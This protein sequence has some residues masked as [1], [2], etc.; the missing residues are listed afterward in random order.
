MSEETAS[1]SWYAR[2]DLRRAAWFA[3]GVLLLLG[4]AAVIAPSF[5]DWN[6]YR[7]EI[8][9]MAERAT[10]RAVTIGGD[11]SFTLLPSPAL[12]VADLRVANLAGFEGASFARLDHL[13]V[14]V[15]ALPLLAGDLNLR[16]LVLNAPVI[17]LE[18]LSD[19]RANWRFP[20][21]ERPA[22][23]E[24]EIRLQRF[25]ISRGRLTYIDHIAGRR[26]TLDSLD[27]RLTAESLAGP[28]R[29][30]GAAELAGAEL[31]FELAT[32]RFGDG[33]RTPVSAGIGFAGSRARYNGWLRLTGDGRAESA[34]D[35]A[36]DGDSLTA[37]LGGVKTALAASEEQ[38]PLPA[39][40][41]KAFSLEGRLETAAVATL[42]AMKAR[43][44][45][46]VFTGSAAVEPEARPRLTL[47]LRADGIDLDALLEG[48]AGPGASPLGKAMP[49]LPLPFDLA[50]SLE[51]APLSFRGEIVN[52]VTLEA[53]S[54]QDKLLVED[55]HASLPGA[56]SG[57]LTGEITSTETG[58]RFVGRAR[59][60]AGDLHRLLD[61][62]GLALP[63]RLGG[64]G[65][66]RISAQVAAEQESIRLTEIDA[67]LDAT[68]LRGELTL[69]RGKEPQQLETSLAIDRLDLDR[70]LPAASPEGAH[71]ARERLMAALG[72]LS[73][74][75][76]RAHIVLDRLRLAGAWMNGVT[77]QLVTAGDALT[78]ENASVRDIFGASAGFAGRLEGLDGETPAE[79]HADILLRADIPEI[80][81]VASWLGMSLP[82]SLPPA[83]LA[84]LTVEGRLVGGG[85]SLE[86]DLSGA[87]A[88]GR[89]TLGG[90]VANAFEE[91]WGPVELALRYDHPSHRALAERF[92]MAGLSRSIAQ[93]VHLDLRLE[94]DAARLAMAGSLEALGGELRF[95]GQRL[96]A[97]NAVEL[98][99][100][101]EAAHPDLRQLIRQFAPAYEP[102]GEDLGGLALTG[103][104]RRD[105]DTLALTEMR[106][107]LGPA[108][109]SGDISIHGV[110]SRPR[111]DA[112]LEAGALS[113]EAFLPAEEGGGPR[114]STAVFDLSP[115]N[116]VDGELALTAESLDMPPYRL[117]AAKMAARL[118][119][120][121]L[122]LD[123]LEGRL[124]GAQARISGRMDTT[125]VLPTMSLALVLDGGD[126]AQALTATFGRSP[127]TGSFDLEGHFA[128]RGNSPF[129]LVNTLSGEAL[130]TVRNGSLEG[131]D[132]SRLATGI[133]RAASVEAANALIDEALSSGNTLLERLEAEVSARNGILRS[134]SLKAQLGGGAMALQ[135]ELDL[136]GW[137]IASSGRLTLA[138]HPQAPPIVLELGGSL[139]DPHGALEARGLRLW[140][141]QRL[142]RAA[143]A[144]IPVSD[145]LLDGASGLP[146]V[147]G[148]AEDGSAKPGSSSGSGGSLP[149]GE[150]A[151]DETRPKS[152][153]P[154]R[155]R[156]GSRP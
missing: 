67:T 154:G 21:L 78:V 10:G 9:A 20:A 106:A 153:S 59:A 57:A 126:A 140:L 119:E 30:T 130:L 15:E 95:D 75:P 36:L 41:D 114:W 107:A 156:G 17:T 101:L 103:R 79:L 88:G 49:D 132:L 29:L 58:P 51:A 70:Y 85:R 62:L 46:A 104:L 42:D 32:N 60:R 66:G 134:Q 12:R 18:R 89:T 37:L 118:E 24:G 28:Y 105:S 19:G 112:R 116:A 131:F 55:L 96:A 139:D 76:G 45:Q 25:E 26:I 94:G 13:D 135:A 11:I 38:A 8:A 64:F 40:L 92:A 141:A 47:D 27:A 77:L 84:P 65:S 148:P 73:S 7:G 113:L 102:R 125:P 133:E 137:S 138:A 44:G 48:G 144:P 33:R 111:F 115:L 4:M 147:V 34:G 23:G 136:A 14:V 98:T 74:V 123:R 152:S 16:R 80:E 1:A 149:A 108:E 39:M 121:R 110:D 87:A 155:S 120:G 143:Y 124:F 72:E 86:L 117:E 99:G 109:I 97:A 35:I 31:D 2:L 100:G 93:P 142:A 127:V 145:S 128:A 146:E 91:S 43:L 22:S 151:S 90:Q 6:R 71:T 61:W 54:E 69:L 63:Q 82:A 5:V 56:S 129:G 52:R 122:E 150:G 53:R 81:P 50:L 3:G 68:A 83:A